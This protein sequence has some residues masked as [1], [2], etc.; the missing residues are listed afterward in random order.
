MVKVENAIAT[1]FE[2]FE[3]VVQALNEARSLQIHKVIGDFIPIEMG[4]VRKASKQG[5][6]AVCT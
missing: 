1:A 2:D 3:F 6:S 4:I 5:G